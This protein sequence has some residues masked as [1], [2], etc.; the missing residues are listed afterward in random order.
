MT[1]I[2]G[3]RLPWW[4]YL[5][6]GGGHL[7]LGLFSDAIYQEGVHV[8]IGWPAIAWGVALLSF[9]GMRLWP[10]LLVASVLLHFG[11]GES[12]VLPNSLLVLGEVSEILVG[13]WL[14][15]WRLDWSKGFYSVRQLRRGALVGI[16]AALVGAG[17]GTSAILIQEEGPV[18]F[19]VSASVFGSWWLRSALGFWMVAPAIG[20]WFNPK[21]KYLGDFP[22]EG[23]IVSVSV[24]TITLGAFTD[25]LFPETTPV[26]V[27]L[28]AGI[29]LVWAGARCG[30]WLAS[31]LSLVVLLGASIAVLSHSSLQERLA[32]GDLRTMWWL[33]LDISAGMATTLAILNGRNAAQ[34]RRLS[35]ARDRL[36]LLVLDSPLALV[37]WDLDFRV[38]RWSRRAAEMFGYSRDHAIGL[39]GL[40][41][42]VVPEDRTLVMEQWAKV[43]GGQPGVRTTNRNLNADGEIIYCDWYGSPVHDELG[44]VSGVIAL[45]EDVSGRKHAELALAASEQ[46]F[47]SVS[48]VLPQLISYYSADLRLLFANAAFLEAHGLKKEQLPLGLQSMVDE[49]TMDRIHPIIAKTLEGIP[50]RFLEKFRFLGEQEHDLDR[51]LLPDLDPDGKV[52]GFFSVCTDITE[53]RAA[54]RERLALETQVLQTQKLESLGLLSGK[55]AHEFN[56]RLFG[57]LGHADMAREDIQRD[58]I[59]AGD[60][61]GKAIEIARE[62]S[63]LCRQLFVYS[64]HGSGCKTTM[65]VNPLVQEMRR[66]LE[67]TLPRT[68]RLNTQL[69]DNLPEI[70]VDAAQVRQAIVNLVQNAAQAMGDDRGEV[71][72]RTR[73]VDSSDCDFRESFLLEQNVDGQDLIEITVRDEGEGME[74][75]DL[76]RVFEPFFTRRPG[77]RGLGLAGV[78]GII[79]GHSGAIGMDSEQDVGTEMRIY[80]PVV[81][82]Q[83]KPDEESPPGPPVTGRE[84]LSDV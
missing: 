80:L 63:D 83:E 19:P 65:G 56:N 64:G 39:H 84:S 33:L 54:A 21:R 59:G 34:A 62:A 17:F 14:I 44:R 31:H 43:L 27:G 7:L 28:L 55:I 82:A 51:I 77:S 9:W 75:S 61:L 24:V 25:L 4:Q 78:V 29:P 13:T 76:D 23:V 22:V 6:V 41:F 30:L 15:R 11:F 81:G 12:G 20:A 46:H 26:W 10:S 38:R 8:S 72:L 36:E 71:L 40:D 58:P 60:N 35:V 57:I 68:V 50:T 67:L 1:E 3:A 37:E 42:L 48:E 45:A 70:Q 32:E 66:L 47:E 69:A 52:R 49:A 2:H 16:A 79:H 74:A 53:Y 18:G 73:L 5:V